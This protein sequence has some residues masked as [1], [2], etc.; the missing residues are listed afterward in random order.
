MLTDFLRLL[1]DVLAYIWPF[2]RVEQ[3]ER[4]CYYI[5]GRHYGGWPSRRVDGTVGPGTW[6]LIPYFMEVRACVTVPTVYKPPLQRVTLRD[7]T[8]LAFRVTIQV[9]VTDAA[10]ATNT[11]ER[12][13][14]T[15]W[16]IVTGVM[17]ERLADVDP[18]RFDPARGKRSRL[19]EELRA[20]CNERT[21]AYG[22]ETQ[23]VWFSDFVV[24]AR[25]YNLLLA[26]NV[27]SI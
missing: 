18:E 21:S 13:D 27:P 9:C 1:V 2:R 11:V 5:L 10:K 6:P 25:T 20:E 15:T 16:E 14:E 12:W 23:A 22:V 7:K 8:S 26:D 4:G 17:G 19:L 24:G 3:W